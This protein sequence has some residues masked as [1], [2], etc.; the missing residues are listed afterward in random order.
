MSYILLGITVV[1]T[2][3]KMV[4]G[5]DSEIKTDRSA[6]IRQTRI[7]LSAVAIVLIGWLLYVLASMPALAPSSDTGYYI[8]V[9]GASLMLLLMTYPLYKRVR[10][11]RL[12]GTTK[13]W[14][15]LH[16]VCGLLGP[17]LIIVHSG[18]NMRSL[19][20]AWAFWSMV[21][22]AGSGIIGRFLYRRIHR[23][24]HGEL[25]TAQTLSA[26]VASASFSIDRALPDDAS[27][28]KDV[29]EFAAR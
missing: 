13:F 21:I 9:V 10:A 19:N 16:M 29:G 5:T 23:G 7:L 8:G 17:A 24:M 22:V 15:R 3:A 18:L 11:F 14:F 27:V 26:A 4:S 28:S 20:A 25:E 12:I 1:I 2:K 6:V